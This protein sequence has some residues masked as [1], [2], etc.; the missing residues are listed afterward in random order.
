[1]RDLATR[2]YQ[3]RRL[4]RKVAGENGKPPQHLAL[5]LGQQ[6]IAPV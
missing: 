2:R 6:F 5:G 4:Y 1:M 3:T